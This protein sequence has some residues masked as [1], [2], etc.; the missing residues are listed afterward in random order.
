MNRRGSIVLYPRLLWHIR[1]SWRPFGLAILLTAAA[2]PAIPMILKPVLDESFI[3]RD[4]SVVAARGDG[5]GE[6]SPLRRRVPADRPL[7]RRP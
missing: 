5:G 7:G 6:V 3:E 1:P 4:P 2:Q